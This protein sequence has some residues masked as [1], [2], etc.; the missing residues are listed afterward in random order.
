MVIYREIFCMLFSDN[1]NNWTFFNLSI[2][3]LSKSCNGFLIFTLNSD[4]DCCNKNNTFG[5][6]E[7]RQRQS[8][9]ISKKYFQKKIYNLLDAQQIS[10]REVNYSSECV[11]NNTKA[12]QQTL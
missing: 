7:I 3:Y 1:R 11:P 9:K 8:T 2:V 12:Q 4:S 5:F 10:V 6:S